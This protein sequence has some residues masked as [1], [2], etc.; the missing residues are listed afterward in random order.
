MPRLLAALLFGAASA[1]PPTPT[2]GPP[3]AGL[4]ALPPLLQF[5]NGTAVRSLAEW[6]QRRTEV[7][8]LLDEH[9]YGT[10]PTVDP[11][12]TSAKVTPTHAAEAVGRGYRE[13]NV[14]LTF[15]TPKGPATFTIDLLVPDMCTK[16][17]PCPTFMTQAN[18]R[19]WGLVG[20]PRGYILL[21]YPGADSNDQTDVFRLTY[22]EA[23]WGMIRRRAW[24]GSR[25]L[26][27]VLSQPWAHKDQVAITG[28][29]RNGKQ[30]LIAAAYDERITAVA[31]SSSGSPAGSPY[32][33]TS[34][35]TF[36]EDPY[37]GWPSCNH[38]AANHCD[39]GC[40]LS[41]V[42]QPDYAK[43]LGKSGGRDPRCC[44]WKPSIMSWEGRENEC[45]IDSHGLYALIAPRHVVGEHAMTDGCDPT[46]AV[47][48]G[49]IAGREV[50]R[51]MGA[52]DR[53]RIDWRQGQHHGFES[54]DRYFDF[55]DV[56]FGRAPKAAGTVDLS[57][58]ATFPEKLLHT[59]D[60]NAW[61]SSVGGPV[62]DLPPAG[63]KA[64]IEWGLGEAPPT[65]P[66]WSPGGEYGLL[67]ATFRS[68]VFRYNLIRVI[69]SNG[70]AF[71][72]CP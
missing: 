39:C 56:A 71:I 13:E 25:A 62:A 44:W 72:G 31:D 27:Y 29:S 69:S 66:G 68:I 7:A 11:P 53:F 28:H 33:L 34:A 18:Q 61:N 52:E 43:P 55:F 41:N 4:A 40:D 60:W 22:P 57:I 47:E 58:E 19:R 5:A 26:D 46:F 64:A 16:A 63:S 3:H 10:A 67:G 65:G 20:L 9:Y 48:G 45:P 36:A 70:C 30:S 59:F 37:G 14:E 32:R 21:S 35:W 49:Y 54:L 2:D 1:S 17:D 15:S 6:P 23:T 24:L 8:A 12:L 38:A 51:F 50:Y 42:S